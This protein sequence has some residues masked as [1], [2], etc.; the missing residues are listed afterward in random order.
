MNILHLFP[1]SDLYTWFTTEL[2]TEPLRT[3]WWNDAE[4][5]VDDP[6]DAAYLVAVA[7]RRP[8]AWAGWCLVDGGTRIQC[9]NNYIRGGYRGRSPDLYE[10]VFLA[11][12][13]QVVAVSRLPAVTYL[14]PEP[15]PL[16]LAHGWQLDT[17]P[18]TSGT[19]SPYVG[20]PVHRW[21]RLS[22]DPA[23]MS[24]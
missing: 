16:H 22:W 7:D 17:G 8:V 2:G 5:S 24:S 21:Q 12:H 1:G 4:S 6:P 13:H 23:V 10:A 14:F 20:G 11:R 9:C 3:Q 18:G 19:S 15:I